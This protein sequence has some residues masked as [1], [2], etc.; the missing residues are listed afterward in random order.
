MS[1]QVD[2][3]KLPKDLRILLKDLM[4]LVQLVV[5]KELWRRRVLL[6]TS[7]CLAVILEFREA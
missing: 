7:K 5:N 3:S 6:Y 2:I 4:D 1:Y